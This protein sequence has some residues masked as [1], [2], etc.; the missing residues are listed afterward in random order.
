MEIRTKKCKSGNIYQLVNE[1]YSNSNGWGHITTII[2]NGYDY[3]PH[4]VRYYNRTWESYPFQTCMSGAVE[5]IYDRE[6]DCYITNYKF[7]NNIDRFK[8]GEKDKVIEMFDKTEMGQDL[9]ELKEAIRDRKF[10][11]I[12][13]K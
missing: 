2:R 3:D 4:K 10:D 11:K 6:L 12:E 13:V 5:T 8:K 7:S 1:G 9:Q